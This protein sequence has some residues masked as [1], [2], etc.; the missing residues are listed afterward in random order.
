MSRVPYWMLHTCSKWLFI[1]IL[2]YISHIEYFSLVDM[3]LDTYTSLLGWESLSPLLVWA[4]PRWQPWAQTW[5]LSVHVQ[6]SLAKAWAPHVVV[7]VYPMTISNI[8][9]SQRADT[10]HKHSFSALPCV[11]L[12]ECHRYH[13]IFFLSSQRHS[14]EIWKWFIRSLGFHDYSF[15]N[16]NLQGPQKAADPLNTKV[17]V[18]K[19]AHPQVPKKS[20]RKA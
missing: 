19:E 9:T 5:Q 7:V 20:R 10:E 17:A 4:P 16:S 2:S 12:P 14:W 11:T 3:N 6:R 1:C 18:S 8:S 13:I 15:M